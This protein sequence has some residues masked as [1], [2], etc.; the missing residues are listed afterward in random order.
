MHKMIPGGQFRYQNWA[1]RGPVQCVE[2]RCE[3]VTEKGW[4]EAERKGLGPVE[5]WGVRR[6]RD[7]GEWVWG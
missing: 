2:C 4:E 1:V 6:L 7:Y 5:K 3:R